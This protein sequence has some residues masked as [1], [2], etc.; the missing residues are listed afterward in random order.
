LV[1]FLKIFD[2]RDWILEMFEGLANLYSISLST[3]NKFEIKLLL[4]RGKVV[5]EG[6]KG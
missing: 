3:P 1:I 5:G 6:R 4:V 2:W